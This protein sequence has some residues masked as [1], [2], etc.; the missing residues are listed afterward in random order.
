MTAR[1]FAD[2]RAPAAALFRREPQHGRDRAPH[3]RLLSLAGFVSSVAGRRS[4]TLVTNLRAQH[5]VD[6]YEVWR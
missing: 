6:L 3:E 2:L 4:S 5:W 1:S